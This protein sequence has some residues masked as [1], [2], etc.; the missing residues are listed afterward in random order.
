[1]EPEPEVYARFASLSQDTLDGLDRFGM[2]DKEKR[3]LLENLTSLAAKLLTISEKEL[4]NQPL[5]G[6][7]YDLI[8][9]YGSIIERYWEAYKLDTYR[10]GLEHSTQLD[11]SLVTDIASGDGWVLQLGTGLAQNM[12]VL[13]PVD[14]TL[15]LASGSVY[16]FYEF[17]NNGQ[18]LTDSE[19]KTLNGF[20]PGPDSGAARPV[21]KPDWTM[22]YRINSS[23]W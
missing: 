2:L 23:N 19:W 16:S 11:A 4:Q 8:R 20:R 5:T 21:D 7:E 22:T 17:L 15:R 18:R 6:E 9:D 3:D 1:M 12:I 14:G 13:V 10:S